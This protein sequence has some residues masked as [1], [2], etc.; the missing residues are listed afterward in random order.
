MTLEE[1]ERQGD[2]TTA[3][4]DNSENQPVF[5]ILDPGSGYTEAPEVVI[6]GLGI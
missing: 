5:T 1:I 3:L 2:G 4:E 6:D